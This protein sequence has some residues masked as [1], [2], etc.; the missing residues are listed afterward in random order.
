[1]PTI[2]F[3]GAGNMAEAIARGLLRTAA[4]QPGDIMATDPDA[5]R[6]RLFAD[7]LGIGQETTVRAAWDRPNPRSRSTGRLW[8]EAS[9]DS[10][11][12]VQHRLERCGLPVGVVPPP[13]QNPSEN[14]AILVPPRCSPNVS[15]CPSVVV[16]RGQAR[17]APCPTRL[18]AVRAIRRQE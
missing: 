14:A 4:Y 9:S 17:F 16:C 13:W 1:M 10:Q 15:A 7:D 5:E 2:G 3:I 6:Q 8:M 18:P 11:S 12:P